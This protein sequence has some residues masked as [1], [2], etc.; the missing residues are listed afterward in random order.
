MILRVRKLGMFAEVSVEDE[1][2]PIKE[3]ER[4][5]VFSRF[6]RGENSRNQ[7]GIG[8]GLYLAREIVMKQKGYMKLTMTEKGNQFSIVLYRDGAQ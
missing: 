3:E 2:G 8:I 6:Y 7:E 1:N 5:K 4:T